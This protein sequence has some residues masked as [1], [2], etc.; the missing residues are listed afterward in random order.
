[1]ESQVTQLTKTIVDNNITKQNQNQ[2]QNSHTEPDSAISNDSCLSA[3]QNLQE[4]IQKSGNDASITLDDDYSPVFQETS[5]FL[6]QNQQEN[7]VEIIDDS[8]TTEITESSEELKLD[9]E[10]SIPL[11]IYQKLMKHQVS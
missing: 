4:K 11:K 10:Y 6:L 5:Q 9:D 7:D 3:L 8:P 2:N 1:M